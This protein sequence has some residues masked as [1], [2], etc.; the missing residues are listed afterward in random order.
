M[1][2]SL[3]RVRRALEAANLDAKIV[4]LSDGTRTAAE[5]ASTVGCDIDQIA[6]S[7]IMAG[8][9]SGQLY[10]FVTAGGKRVDE[11]KAAALAGEHLTR[12]D[13]QVVRSRTGFAIG[14]VSPVGHLTSVNAFFDSHL[15]K[16][17]QIWAA[18]GTP[19]HVFGCDPAALL[20]ILDTQA[21]DFTS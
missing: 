21:S 6:K 8:S 12:A 18:A 20:Q 3:N 1:S 2:K 10:L 9:N 5:A 16:F 7:V 19:H 13:A 15:L 17:S 4:E 14:G 11:E